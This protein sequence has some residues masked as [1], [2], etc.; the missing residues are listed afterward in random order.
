MNDPIEAVIKIA[1]S[2]LETQSARLRIVAENL[3]NG[4]PV[5]TGKE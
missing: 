2:G 1:G 4:A 5:E 3:A